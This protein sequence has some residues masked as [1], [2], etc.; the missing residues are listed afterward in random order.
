M[1]ARYANAEQ[2]RRWLLPLLEGRIRSCFAMTEPTVASSDATNI[3]IS[4]ARDEA[5]GE[6]VINGSKWWCTG[7]GS[8]HCKIMILMGKTRTDG[9]T[10]PSYHPCR[11]MILMGKTRTDGPIHKQQSQL[12]V[13][14]DTPGTTLLL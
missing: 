7:A 6:Y 4:I 8:L 5:R 3:G 1:L 12:L 11:I 14:M 10:L 13:P 9:E 2:R